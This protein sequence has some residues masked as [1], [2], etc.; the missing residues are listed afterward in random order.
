MPGIFISG[1]D[2][3]KIATLG[4]GKGRPSQIYPSLGYK[5]G[6]TH[7]NKAHDPNITIP[8]KRYCANKNAKRGRRGIY[9]IGGVVRPVMGGVQIT[10]A[11][12]AALPSH[13]N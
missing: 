4:T 13:C 12:L 1:N 2:G 7:N 11:N 3:I 6:T 5:F 8:V 9:G 10:Q